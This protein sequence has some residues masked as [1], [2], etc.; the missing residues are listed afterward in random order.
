MHGNYQVENGNLRMQK[1]D[2]DVLKGHLCA[3][4]D[5][6]HL[7][8]TPA[9]SVNATLR[10]VSLESL[11]DAMPANTRQNVRLLGR[12]NLTAQANWS[13]DISAMKPR[14]HLDIT[15]PTTLPP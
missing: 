4:M 6:L 12:M 11:S 9:S 2:A 3:K 8:S 14:S 10:G 5:M 13:K 1:L 7:D 15:G